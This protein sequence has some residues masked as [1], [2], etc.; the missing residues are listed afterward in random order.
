[1]ALLRQ[2]APSSR[3][4]NCLFR[5]TATLRLLIATGHEIHLLRKIHGFGQY[6]SEWLLFL[7][8]LLDSPHWELLIFAMPQ[9]ELRHRECG[10][11]MANDVAV[12]PPPSKRH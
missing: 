6:L 10:L 2:S 7:V 11:R 12:S 8:G 9:G 1:M 5:P 3:S 4:R